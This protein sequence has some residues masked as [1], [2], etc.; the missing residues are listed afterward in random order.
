MK[1]HLKLMLSGIRAVFAELV[2]VRIFSGISVAVWPEAPSMGT[3][4]KVEKHV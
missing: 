4:G 1:V 2:K 3:L